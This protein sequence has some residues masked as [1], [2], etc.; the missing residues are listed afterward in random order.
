[1]KK[2]LIIWQFIQNSLQKHL[3]IMLLYVVESSG[4]SPGRQGFLMAVNSNNE[5]EGS[6]GGGVMEHKF[7]EKA[8]ASLAQKIKEAS[9]YK[10]IHNK[11]ASK[12]QSGMICSGEQTIF[13]YSVQKK[14]AVCIDG[15][16]NCIKENQTVTLYLSPSGILFDNSLALKTFFFNYTSDNEWTYIEL[17]GFKNKLYIIGGGH[18]ALALSRL[19]RTMNFYITVIDERNDLNTMKKNVH[20][21]KLICIDNYS[22]INEHVPH[23]ENNYVVIMTAGYRTDDI[24]IRNIMNRNFK[25]LGILGSKN[26]IQKMFCDYKNEGVQDDILNKIHAPIGIQIKSQTPQEIAISIAAEIIKVKNT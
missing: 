22:S 12:N 19:M 10:Q 7:V 11:S 9:L 8:K 15:I 6:I 21:H 13:M 25:Y 1:M 2:Q 17:L 24:V 26:K 3:D 23:G 20:A 5:M 14:D 4:S 16:L 18:C